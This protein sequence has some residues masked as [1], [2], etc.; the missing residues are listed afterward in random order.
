MSFD[1]RMFPQYESTWLQGD[2]DEVSRTGHPAI[3][4]PFRG[5][6]DGDEPAM[7][8]TSGF[9]PGVASYSQPC[10]VCNASTYRIR[11]RFIDL[12]VSVFTPVHR[13]RCRSLK[14]I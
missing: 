14:C 13:Y 12:L 7:N 6:S 11:R 9:G 8:G 3:S 1:R 2:I 5:V 10:L 4:L